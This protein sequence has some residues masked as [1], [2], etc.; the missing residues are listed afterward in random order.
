MTTASTLL[1]A[2]LK[3]VF[4]ERDAGR[5]RRAIQELYAADS[6]LYEQDDT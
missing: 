4:N 2:N 6:T 5:R 3:R 1:Q